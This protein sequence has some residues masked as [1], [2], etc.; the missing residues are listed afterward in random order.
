MKPHWKLIASLWIFSNMTMLVLWHLP[1]S[2]LRAALLIRPVV[3]YLGFLEFSHTWGPFSPDP[4]FPSRHMEAEVIF[5]DGSIKIWYFPRMS[6]MSILERIVKMRQG[7]W[8]EKMQTIPAFYPDIARYI[9]RLYA[10]PNNP[11]RTVTFVE[12]KSDTPAPI[13]GDYQPIPK[14]YPHVTR[15]PP[16]F[17]YKVLPEDMR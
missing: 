13:P 10:N 8:E 5:K 3:N 15:L 11:P 2:P 4:R 6:R 9:A 14:E 1:V 12:Y 7:I 16:F 17:V